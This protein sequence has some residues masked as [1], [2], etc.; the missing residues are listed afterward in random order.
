VAG[1]RGLF[2]PPKAIARV[3]SPLARAITVPLRPLHIDSYATD[4]SHVRSLWP[5][6]LGVSSLSATRRVFAAFL[7]APGF[8]CSGGK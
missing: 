7:H 1:L 8:P 5:S 3:P 2:K 6:M 4:T